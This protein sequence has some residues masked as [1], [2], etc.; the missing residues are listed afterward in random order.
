[1]WLSWGDFG[2]EKGIGTSFPQSTVI[3]SSIL[4]LLLMRSMEQFGRS[5]NELPKNVINQGLLKQFIHILQ[6][7]V[8]G[9]GKTFWKWIWTD[10]HN[11]SILPN[12]IF[13]FPTCWVMHIS[14]TQEAYKL[15]QS[16]V[17][18]TLITLMLHFSLIV[19]EINIKIGY[20]QQQRIDLHINANKMKLLF[21]I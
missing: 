2:A 5:G 14:C 16:I 19:T 9:I 7:C 15:V 11:D 1:M 4:P 21:F 17:S 13:N 6:M 12:L 18:L 3:I 20:R 10:V 8:Y